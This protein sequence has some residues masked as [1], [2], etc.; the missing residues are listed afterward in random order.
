MVLDVDY[1][2]EQAEQQDKIDLALDEVFKDTSF[3][4]YNYT[5]DYEDYDSL[6]EGI[7]EQITEHEVIYYGVAMEYLSEHD[8][9]L[10]ESMGLAHDMGYSCQD[11]N[12]E[13]LA[14]LLQQQNLTEELN[15]LATEL[16]ECFE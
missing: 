13:L 6:Y 16:E 15:N 4:D 12:S 1:D 5:G 3:E 2:K 14:T 9:S 7:Q 8:S 11:V 10:K